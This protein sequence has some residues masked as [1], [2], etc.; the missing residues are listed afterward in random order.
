[1]SRVKEILSI[2]LLVAGVTLVFVGVTRSVGFSLAGIIASLAAVVALLYSGAVF[3]GASL[4]PHTEKRD[5][6]F[7]FDRTIRL[8]GGAHQG[9]P[10]RAVL[11]GIAEGDLE[12][13]CSAVFSG[14]TD[15]FAY[16]AATPPMHVD[17]V[18]VRDVDGVVVLGM[19]IVNPSR[20]AAPASRV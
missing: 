7:V 19:V 5:T 20:H 3:F 1:M 18:P 8:V 10:I 6:I 16:T 15:R 4:A 9:M 11:R 2:A 13:R 17:I 14:K 12:S